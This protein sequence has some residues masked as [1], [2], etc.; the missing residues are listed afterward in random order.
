LSKKQPNRFL[1]HLWL[2]PATGL[3]L[4]PGG[5][6]DAE[7]SML[8][9]ASAC[10]AILLAV[11][12]L[13]TF[14][15]P[16]P[17]FLRIPL[18]LPLLTPAFAALFP[19][20]HPLCLGMLLLP[21]AYL[22][23]QTFQKRIPETPKTAILM[24][25]VLLTPLC[26]VPLEIFLELPPDR[27]PTVVY[28]QDMWILALLLIPVGLSIRPFMRPIAR[29]IL[30]GEL[31]LLLI[32]LWLLPWFWLLPTSFK[33]TGE[34]IEVPDRR[35]PLPRLVIE[36][37]TDWQPLLPPAFQDMQDPFFALQTWEYL[38]RLLT[39]TSLEAAFTG[40]E[41]PL[42]P[43]DMVRALRLYDFIQQD[44]HGYFVPASTFNRD[45]PAEMDP[46]ADL[47]IE[48]L[49]QHVTI[50]PEKVAQQLQADPVEALHLLRLFEQQDL[51]RR[52]PEGVNHFRPSATSRHP[53]EEGWRPHQILMSATTTEPD[54]FLSRQKY[55]EDRGMKRFQALREL[56]A[57]LE[58]GM[59]Q[60]VAMW[61]P[62]QYRLL[63]E[64]RHR[65]RSL[66]L[67]LASVLLGL[68]AGLNAPT[69]TTAFPRLRPWVP[70]AGLLLFA[71]WPGE[72][73]FW[74]PARVGVGLWLFRSLGELSRRQVLQLTAFTALVAL[75]WISRDLA[76][77]TSPHEQLEVQAAWALLWVL[78][79]LILL[80]LSLYTPRPEKTSPD[81]AVEPGTPA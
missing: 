48:R 26:A 33:E 68:V 21:W 36:P 66:G 52:V 49:K 7:P 10:S 16:I 67:L 71:A 81:E 56:D 44:R 11:C 47:W 2:I 50:T 6:P 40:P 18:A 46:D 20:N 41:Y 53:T 13:L 19:L 37:G 39:P 32:P 14:L 59:I 79:G 78:P 5:L 57:M 29:N 54:V 72:A 15:G 27:F 61:Q 31:I 73:V 45:I 1:A 70:V 65:L 77:A 9:V 69:L 43:E 42:A 30:K 12:N 23:Y 55:G 4:Y 25:W 74:I 38:T 63:L 80:A 35:L 3:L 34:S 76:P 75:Q 24:T 58:Q 51:I 64:D 22:L 60:E 62:D 28:H 17:R 8:L